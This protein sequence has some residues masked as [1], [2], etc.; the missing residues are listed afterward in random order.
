MPK[1]GAGFHER[2]RA[3]PGAL[4]GEVLMDDASRRKVRRHKER[5]MF[6]VALVIGGLV[7]LV[8]LYFS[9]FLRAQNIQVT[10]TTSLDP[11]AVAAAASAQG[12]SLISSDFAGPQSRVAALPQV[13][14][15]TIEKHWPSTIEIKVTERAPWAT[16]AEG[17]AMYTI[18]D[19][20]VVLALAPADAGPIIHAPASDKPLAPGDHVEA[21][22][23]QLTHTLVEQV[24]AQ[25]GVNLTQIDWSNDKGVTVTT[26][27]GYQV[28]FGD[29]N[30]MQYKFAVW[31]GIEN[32]FGK[33]SMSGHVLDLRFGQRPSF[34]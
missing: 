30:D 17:E 4:R 14:S 5:K 28:V 11:A 26:D 20:G 27:A 19:T 1:R 25:L 2:R 31:Q 10:G 18:D 12:A 3:T 23:L 15:V 7:S 24:P 16:W 34:N 13:K 32:E 21:A 9:P 33:D 8:A 29:S 22:A 6:A